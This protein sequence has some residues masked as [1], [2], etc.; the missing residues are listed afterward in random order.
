[1]DQ[2]TPTTERGAWKRGIPYQN[3]ASSTTLTPTSMNRGDLICFMVAEAA[4]RP[5]S[6]VPMHDPGNEASRSKLL[7]NAHLIV[8]WV[9]LT[10][11]WR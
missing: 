5:P 6:L 10:D 3:A 4:G 2:A 7:L 8:P 9:S 11:I 1:M